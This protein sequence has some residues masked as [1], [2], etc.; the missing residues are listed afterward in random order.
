[1]DEE[2]GVLE[3]AGA[4]EGVGEGGCG[5]EVLVYCRLLLFRTAFGEEEDDGLDFGWGIV[6]I[7]VGM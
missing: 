3:G 4:A 5:G 2:A 7:A 1:M 6:H